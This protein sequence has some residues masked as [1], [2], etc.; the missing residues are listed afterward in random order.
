MDICAILLHPTYHGRVVDECI[1]RIQR[2]L[3]GTTSGVTLVVT[4]L[5]SPRGMALDPS[6]NLV[7]PDLSYSRIILYPVNC[8]K[9]KLTRIICAVIFFSVLIHIDVFF[10]MKTTSTATGTTATGRK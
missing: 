6:G 10:S 5:S 4:V 1:I 3:S 7:V 9:Y 8:R 2:W